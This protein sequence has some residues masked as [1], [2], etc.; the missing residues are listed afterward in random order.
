[1][2]EICINT[3]FIKLDSMLKLA[4]VAE[5]G[6]QAKYF[7]SEGYIFVNDEVTLLRGKKLHKGDKI[8]VKFEGEVGNFVII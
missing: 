4:G 6:G 5:T 7:I 1:M 2:I 8:T 3:E